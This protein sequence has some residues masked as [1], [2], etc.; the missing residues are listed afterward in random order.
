MR[1]SSVFT[2]CAPGGAIARV[3]IVVYGELI[4]AAWDDARLANGG[5]APAAA[6]GRHSSAYLHVSLPVSV[7]RF[8][9][10]KIC[11]IPLMTSGE[12]QQ[13]VRSG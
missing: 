3:V 1:L 12:A 13:R 10:I 9:I 11:I 8:V 4:A 5:R 2:G 6:S 7:F